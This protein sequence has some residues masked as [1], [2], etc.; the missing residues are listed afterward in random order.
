MRS[1]T[2]RLYYDTNVLFFDLGEGSN[3]QCDRSIAAARGSV[4]ALPEL[5]QP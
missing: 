1:I 2:A 5:P 3:N 4:E